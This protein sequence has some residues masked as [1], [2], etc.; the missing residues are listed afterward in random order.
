MAPRYR[1]LLADLLTRK[2]LSD[3]APFTLSSYGRTLNGA[4]DASGTLDLSDPATRLTDPIGSTE[5]RRT[6][7]WIV[8][9]TDLVWGGIIWTRKYSAANRALEITASTPES[10]FA[11]RL[12]RSTATFSQ[13]GQHA[14]IR[15]LI[16]TAQGAAHGN[17]GVQIP[18][19]TPGTLRDRNYLWHERATVWDR[20]T[21]LC[22]IDGGPDVTITPGWDATG[23]PSWYLNVGTPLG[24]T[25]GLELD[26]PGELHDYSW[27]E[28][29]GASANFISAVGGTVNDIPVIR[30]ATMSR[31]WEAGIPLLEDTTSYSDATVAATL[32]AHAQADVKAAA[33][34]RIVPEL[35]VRLT[36]NADLPQPG[37]AYQLRISDPYRFPPDPL[38][39]AP[40]L[41]LSAVRVTG[42]EVNVSEGEGEAISLT[43]TGVA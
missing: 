1:F 2:L 43:V 29:G 16:A 30:D 11:R 9:D 15:S 33:G 4:S 20:V 39:G 19:G 26:F 17:I 3:A 14:I 37:D 35:S 5:P 18:A 41:I 13:V 32:S 6:A 31:E 27:P 21:E 42:W 28:D 24:I 36:E 10:Y 40:S 38:S 12:I 8:R 23:Q 7:L 25:R 34:N 22:E